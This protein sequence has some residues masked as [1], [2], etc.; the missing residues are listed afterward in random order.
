MPKITGATMQLSPEQ[1]AQL[2]MS[3]DAAG[4]YDVSGKAMLQPG[5]VMEFSEVEVYPVEATPD[6]Q[7]GMGFA[8]ASTED[9][10]PSR[11]RR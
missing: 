4:E 10:I 9:D 6:Q 1:M 11:M 7:T 8:M 5:G 2:G 3:P